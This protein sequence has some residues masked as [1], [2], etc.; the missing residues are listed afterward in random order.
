MIVME[1]LEICFIMLQISQERNSIRYDHHRT[2][3]LLRGFV[4]RLKV[5]ILFHGLTYNFMDALYELL[6]KILC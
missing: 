3:N 6:V 4:F 2:L 5:S 1:I